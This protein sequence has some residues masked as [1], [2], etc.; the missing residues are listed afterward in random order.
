M[1][2]FLIAGARQ[3]FMKIAPILRALTKSNPQIPHIRY[4]IKHTG[5]HYDYKM[6][7][8]FFND[9]VLPKPDINLEVGSGF[10][11]EQIAGVMAK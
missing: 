1:K 4:K 10:H 3:N 9:L 6:S 5:Q 2:F 11:A 7:Q 8:V